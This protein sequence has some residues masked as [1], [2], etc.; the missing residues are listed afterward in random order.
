MLGLNPE[1]DGIAQFLPVVRKA[2]DP[3][4]SEV[5]EEHMTQLTGHVND[6]LTSGD[7]LA[8]GDLVTMETL[9]RRVGFKQLGD[10]L[11]APADVSPR[12]TAIDTAVAGL[13]AV[14]PD[15]KLE[16]RS[17]GRLLEGD[18]ISR[19]HRRTWR[20]CTR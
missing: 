20:S 17:F 16:L 14:S 19:R 7:L 10:K 5:T 2:I 3:T 9:T 8:I 18:A 12:I 6:L 15:R 13:P 4:V 1:D 11:N